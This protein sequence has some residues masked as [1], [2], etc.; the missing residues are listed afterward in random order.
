MNDVKFNDFF[1]IWVSLLGEGRYQ[2]LRFLLEEYGS[3][4]KIIAIEN[5][6]DLTPALTTKEKLVSNI[7]NPDKKIE[8]QRICEDVHRLGMNIVTLADN[9]YP[10]YL[11]EIYAPPLVLYYYGTLP[12]MS[13]KAIAVVGSRTASGYGRNTAYRLSGEL[14]SSGITIVSGMA[15]GV[16]SYA[17]KGALEAGCSTVAVLGCG[18][19][20]IYPP[21]NKD[22]YHKITKCG[23]VV[24]EFYPGTMPQKQFFPARNRIIAGLC[25]GTLV[26]EARRS[27]GALITAD[28]AI[29]ENRTVYAVPGN[30]NSELSL[31]TNKLIQ[32]GAVCVTCAQDILDD[33]GIEAK[34]GS[35]SKIEGL[36]KTQI[37]VCLAILSN[38]RSVEEVCAATNLDVATV[39]A[40]TTWLKINGIIEG[41]GF[42]DYV[43]K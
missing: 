40:T 7:L 6:S 22:L 9:D 33:I 29:R 26:I 27:S 24:S 3:P 25:V 10:E 30:I 18:A 21:E 28:N 17:H 20:Y 43:V 4:E 32:K 23:A 13:E 38:A 42:G 41:V 35:E 15:R 2:I 31:G 14:A 34:P 16:D 1:Y 5:I 11:K 8:A 36:D 19:D 12:P 37:A 39:L